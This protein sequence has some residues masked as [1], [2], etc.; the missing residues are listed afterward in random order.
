MPTLGTF[1]DG[2]LVSQVVGAHAKPSL[3]AQIDALLPK[4]TGPAAICGDESCHDRTL[5]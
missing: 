1:R 2:E 4:R 3:R 5:W